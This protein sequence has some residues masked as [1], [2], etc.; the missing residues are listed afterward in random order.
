V[1]LVAA[2]VAGVLLILYAYYVRSVSPPAPAVETE[3]TVFGKARFGMALEQMK[4]LYPEM[5]D[6]KKSLGAAVAEGQFIARRVLWK[7]KLPGLPEPTDVELRF[8]K[9]QLWV[10]ITY[11]GANDLDTVLKTLTERYGPPQGD[12]GTP[13]WTG[14]KSTVI[15]AAKARW[16]SVHDNAIS[17]EAQTIFIEDLKRSLERRA[18]ARRGTAAEGEHGVATAGPVLATPAAT[19]MAGQ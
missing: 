11:F 8:W 1:S 16:Y 6:L 9:N 18:A 3:P 17:K 5:E 14:A 10:V 2:A 13:V 15:V 4:A 12:P 7:Q 19:V